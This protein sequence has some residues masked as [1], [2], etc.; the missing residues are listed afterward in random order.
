[1]SSNKITKIVTAEEEQIRTKINAQKEQERK[2]D[3]QGF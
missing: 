3:I 1:L 2:K